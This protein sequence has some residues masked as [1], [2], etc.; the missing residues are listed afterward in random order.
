MERVLKNDPAFRNVFD[1]GESG[2]WE[3][4]RETFLWQ[5]RHHG[6]YHRYCSLLKIDPY[7][8]E[9]PE[10]IPF[11]P[12]GFFKTHL[13]G[14]GNDSS[15]L[16]FRSSGTTAEIRSRHHVLHPEWYE[17]SFRRTF[18]LF[19][20]DPGKY[21]ILCL[22]PDYRH[23][24]ESSL[25]FM[26]NRLI[27]DS[28]HPESG[29]Y[30]QDFGSLHRVL[31]DLEQKGLQALL[32]GVTYALLDFAE[33]YPV[34]LRNTLVMETGGMKGRREE[35]TRKAAHEALKKAF[36]CTHIHS[37]YGMTEL[38]SQAYSSSDGIFRCPPWMKMLIRDET[39]PLCLREPKNHPVRG[40]V[41][42]IDLANRFSCPF[43]ATDDAGILYPDGSFEITGRL[44][45]SD[46]R[47]CSL[48]SL[49]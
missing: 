35:I 49:E 48:M 36:G 20:G 23:K 31:Q 33:Q 6:L 1:V 38:L 7:A 21:R 18:R 44:D 34:P 16:L 2:F 15:P 17:E 13:V 39:D 19:Y 32:L 9:R 41:N 40:A 26:C 30:L 28:G 37:E 47:G 22:V 12:I 11:L 29:F 4:C 3:V 14:M 46:I 5:Y 8:V 25:A 45:H 24:P 27:G 43:I 42:I 10:D